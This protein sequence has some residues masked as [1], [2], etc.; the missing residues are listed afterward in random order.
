MRFSRL[1]L[2]SVFSSS[3]VCAQDEKKYLNI[4]QFNITY[5]IKGNS[6]INSFPEFESGEDIVLNYNFTN[7]EN[8]NVSVVGLGGNIVDMRNLEVIANITRGDINPI[9]ISINSTGT[10]QQKLTLN[11][12]EGQYY[13]VP[14]IFVVKNETLM[15]VE[16]T[17][18][19]LRIIPSFM[20]IFNPKFL[21]IQAILLGIV[22]LISYYF[23]YVKQ[24]SKPKKTYVN[25]P[26][27]V[28]SS[29]I[30]ETYKR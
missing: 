13:I 27:K 23:V 18:H 11:L 21:F 25:K 9:H 15:N 24:G 10:F 8:N 19:T 6:E 14:N 5:N 22:G 17:P 1:F 2:L 16:A 3:L 20:S 4:A 29:W 28:D 7:Y 30:P 12:E 26:I